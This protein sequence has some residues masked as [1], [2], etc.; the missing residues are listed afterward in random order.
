MVFLMVHIVYNSLHFQNYILLHTHTHH[1]S[2]SR[3]GQWSRSP[4]CSMRQGNMIM[5]ESQEQVEGRHKIQFACFPSPFLSSSHSLIPSPTPGL[6]IATVSR[7]C[8]PFYLLTGCDIDNRPQQPLEMPPSLHALSFD[9][10][11]L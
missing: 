3:R 4:G 10:A 6:S 1:E 11:F 2:I 8:R 5:Y 7:G 9:V